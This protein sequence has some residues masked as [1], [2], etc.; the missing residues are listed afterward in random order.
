[1]LEGRR[2]KVLSRRQGILTG[3][4]LHKADDGQLWAYVVLFDD[5]EAPVK[6]DLV[7]RLRIDAEE[8]M[9]RPTLRPHVGQWALTDPEPY[10][11]VSSKGRCR[12]CLYPLGAEDTSCPICEGGGSAGDGGRSCTRAGSDRPPKIGRSCQL[13]Q[14]LAYPKKE[15]AM[16]SQATLEKKSGKKKKD[17]GRKATVFETKRVYPYEDGCFSI[18]T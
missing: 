1:M 15:S 11:Q 6:Q 8:A 17:L 14:E 16:R 18:G 4:I 13:A 5:T 7:R 2:F 9:P 3:R 10:Y 12:V